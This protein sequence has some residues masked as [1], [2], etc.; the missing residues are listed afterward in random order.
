MCIRDSNID[1][2]QIA[3]YLEQVKD[4]VVSWATQGVNILLSVAKAT[5]EAIILIFVT[6]VAVFYWCRDEEKVKGV[7][8][9][10]LPVKF[11]HR[12]VATYDNFSTVIGQY[13]RAQLILITISFVICKMCI[14]DS[15]SPHALRHSFATHL[16]DNG[17][18]IRA[19]QELLGHESIGTTQKYTCLLYT[20]ALFDFAAI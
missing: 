18:D 6:L 14:R 11:R 12:A 2:E 4:L 16:L 20:S 19:I 15:I 13:I 17:A 9:N 3:V 5:P 1:Y 7:L 10:A 8:C